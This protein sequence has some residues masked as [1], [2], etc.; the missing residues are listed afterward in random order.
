MPDPH[1]LMLMALTDPH[2]PDPSVTTRCFRV[3]FT[4]V[5]KEITEDFATM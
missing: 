3:D 4:P 1:G 2:G 5:T